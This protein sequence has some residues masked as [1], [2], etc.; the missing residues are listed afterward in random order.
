MVANDS[1]VGIDKRLN[2]FFLAFKP[3]RKS[4]SLKDSLTLFFD[5]FKAIR[6]N[7]FFK[8]QIKT[9]SVN[10][11]SLRLWLTELN[12]PL[13]D[14]RR[15]AF[16]CKPW[17]LAGLNRDEVR[18]SSILAWILNPRGNHGLG[19]FALTAILQSLNKSLNTHV[20]TFPIEVERDCVVRTEYN[21]DGDI[22]NRVDI[23]IEGK[24]FYL[25]IEV[26]IDAVE[27]ENQI[28]R[29]GN[30]SEKQAR[31]R[32]WLIVYLTPSGKAPNTAG[33]YK[34]KVVCMSWLEISKLI[35]PTLEKKHGNQIR[36]D[37]TV[38]VRQLIIHFLNHI[39]IF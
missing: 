10:H 18:N 26:K 16:H 36:T 9:Y 6:S 22:S 25:I 11:E 32:P 13:I 39:A 30:I 5:S 17:E 20:A 35:R 14:S 33:D 15:G 19:S 34:E 24:S 21:P 4:S 31:E 29:Y 8:P 3:L 23:Q 27:G 7:L 12:S 1:E 38:M 28:Q 2:D 37:Q